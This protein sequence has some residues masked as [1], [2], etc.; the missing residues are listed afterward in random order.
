MYE[1]LHI[2]DIILLNNFQIK[3]IVVMLIY[4]GLETMAIIIPIGRGLKESTQLVS[5]SII[6]IFNNTYI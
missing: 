2:D 3:L 1:S 4:F 6:N 5:V